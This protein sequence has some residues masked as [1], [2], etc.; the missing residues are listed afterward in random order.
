MLGFSQTLNRFVA[1]QQIRLRPP[2]SGLDVLTVSACGQ[3]VAVAAFEG[4]VALFPALH[5]GPQV[6]L[7]LAG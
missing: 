2:G 3:A 6:G 1:L 7:S 5:S 4:L